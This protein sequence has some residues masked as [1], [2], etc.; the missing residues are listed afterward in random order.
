ML[1]IS[2]ADTTIVLLDMEI[3]D[4]KTF[5]NKINYQFKDGKYLKEALRHSSY[6]NEQPKEDLRDNERL[7]FLG[8][9]VLNL[10][11]SHMLMVKD[12]N[13]NEGNLS[14]IRAGMVNESQLAH[15]ARKIDLGDYI[16]LGKGEMQTNGRNKNS[17]LAD[18]LEAVIAAVYLD[19]GF[20]QVFRIIE[21]HFSP[22]IDHITVLQSALDYKSRL[23]E[24]VQTTRKA[25][26]RYTVVEESGPDH[27]K[28]FRVKAMVL[29]IEAEGKGKSKKMAE[30][31]AA[32]NVMTLLT[33]PT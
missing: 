25:V 14:Q 26:P 16:L 15:L 2:K 24:L 28:T 4:Y 12:P 30:Q 13:L 19:G 9:A 5:E 8:D 7:E 29:N 21:F 6:V 20:R 11:I 10:V 33:G 18:T 3:S 1:S 17:I 23:Q 22:L 27:D 32:K 31:D